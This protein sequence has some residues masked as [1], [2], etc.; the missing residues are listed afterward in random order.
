[1]AST[2]EKAIELLFHL[3][4]VDGAQGVSVLARNTG[5]PKANVFRQLNALS[6]RD[7]VEQDE[8][9]RYQ[10][11]F[12]LAGLG[13]RVM[14]RE[15]ICAAARPELEAVMEELGETAFLA[16]ARGGRLTI[17][18]KVEGNGFIRATPQI[19]ATLPAHATAVGK[20]YLAL[21]PEQLADAEDHLEAYTSATITSETVLKRELGRIRKRGW[22]ANEGEWLR[23]LAVVAAP[24][25]SGGRL[26][27]VV[28]L[29]TTSGRME[30]LGMKRVA[31]RLMEAAAATIERLES[32]RGRR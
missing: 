23:G 26:R 4:E 21:A 15:P 32:E 16:V 3:S 17:A 13:M 25:E 1:M 28:V 9:G 27:G 24:I 11:G 2:I 29:A 20:L 18:D 12:G 8:S 30:E 5:Q 14:E 10:L 19:G 7:L 31:A 22:A 6:K